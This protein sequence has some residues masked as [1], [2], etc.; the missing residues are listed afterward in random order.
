MHKPVLWFVAG[1]NG[2]GKTSFAFKHI[3]AISGSTDFVN[4]DEIARGLSPI[5]PEAGRLRAAR[6]ALQILAESL[7]LEN[8][9]AKSFTIESTLAGRTHLKTIEDARKAGWPVHI[10]YFAVKTPE[11]AL[12][13]IAR[14]VSVGGHDVPEA[15][16]RRRF[17]RSLANLPE[18]LAE[19]DFWR[20]YDNNGAQPI[21]VAEGRQGCCAF[22]AEDWSGLPEGLPQLL[23]AMPKCA[24]G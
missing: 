7:R 11:I 12:A 5:N 8:G 15:D 23:A 10:L 14:R 21:P 22:R 13:R 1:A 2:V 9:A 24:E 19:C 4:L 18:Y 6:V 17:S 20:V 3:S 16:A